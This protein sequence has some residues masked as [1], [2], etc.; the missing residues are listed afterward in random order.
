MAIAQ[1]GGN[2][3]TDGAG[4][5]SEVAELLDA[6]AKARTVDHELLTPAALRR[7]LPALN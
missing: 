6:V 3:H 4:H 7:L 5:G 2:D 1:T